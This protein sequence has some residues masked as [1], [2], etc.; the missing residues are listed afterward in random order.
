MELFLIMQVG[1]LS[2]G[3]CTGRLGQKTR[4]LCLTLA[5]VVGNSKSCFSL[6]IFL[7]VFVSA[8]PDLGACVSTLARIRFYFTTFCTSQNRMR[9]RTLIRNSCLL[10][11]WHTTRVYGLYEY[12][13]A[14]N[15]VLVIFQKRTHMNTEGRF[16]CPAFSQY[17]E[18]MFDEHD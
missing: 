6:A 3:F 12:I 11:P 16:Y 4:L 13:T 7:R 17:W 18:I 1:V 9:L 8:H 2:F 15:F 10:K 14:S 5:R